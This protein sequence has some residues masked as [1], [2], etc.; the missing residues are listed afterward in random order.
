MLRRSLIINFA[1]SLF[2]TAVMM[3]A[4][5]S[6]NGL[7]AGIRASFSTYALDNELLSPL[8]HRTLSL[9]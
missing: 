1:V 5:P 7:I 9:R 8:V 2:S 3:S 4:M 6:S